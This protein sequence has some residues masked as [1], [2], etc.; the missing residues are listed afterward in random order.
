M[1]DIG[2]GG[3]EGFRLVG[4][5]ECQGRKKGVGVVPTSFFLFFLSCCGADRSTEPELGSP[6]PCRNLD[7]ASPRPK[8]KHKPKPTESEKRKR[9]KPDDEQRNPLTE[10]KKV[11]TLIAKQSYDRTHSTLCCNRG[12]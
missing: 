7:D 12:V 11:I 3:G 1:V 4:P 9:K 2:V 6:G 5:V 10:K 8:K